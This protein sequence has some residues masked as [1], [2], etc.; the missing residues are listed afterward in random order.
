MRCRLVNVAGLRC[1]HDAGHAGPH[2]PG[3]P[4]PADLDDESEEVLE[5]EAARDEEA[6]DV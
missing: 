5:Q 2:E 3:A 6:D 1:R 4:D